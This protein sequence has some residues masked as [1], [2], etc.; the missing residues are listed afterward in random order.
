MGDRSE[1]RI[2]HGSS[3]YSIWRSL[4]KSLLPLGW[5]D[6]DPNL[7]AEKRYRIALSKVLINRKQLLVIRISYTL[8]VMLVFGSVFPPLGLIAGISLLIVTV[9]EERYTLLMLTEARDLALK[10]NNDPN[11]ESREQWFEKYVKQECKDVNYV[12]TWIIYF[13]IILSSIMYGMIIFDSIGDEYGWR[14]GLIGGMLMIA[15]GLFITIFS[16]SLPRIRGS[17][18]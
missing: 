5:K 1:V 8:G 7:D 17:T 11:I 18:L 10:P 2:S 4:L 9:V 6:L 14:Y 15:F 12:F 3:F 16:L 13:V